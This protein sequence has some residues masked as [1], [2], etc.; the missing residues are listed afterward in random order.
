MKQ[1]YSIRCSHFREIR[2]IRHF[3]PLKKSCAFA[4]VFMTLQVFHF[5]P[6][7]YDNH[8]FLKICQ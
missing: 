2:E 6:L 5:C 1:T 4:N 8:I 3:R 7:E